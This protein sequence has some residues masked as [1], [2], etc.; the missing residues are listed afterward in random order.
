MMPR[1]ISSPRRSGLPGA[2]C[3]FLATHL[4]FRRISYKFIAATPSTSHY[5]RCSLNGLLLFAVE[6]D[7]CLMFRRMMNH[8]S[9][10]AHLI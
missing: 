4:A 9:L 1:M 8:C 5:S 3:T 10:E 2:C 7:V 6:L